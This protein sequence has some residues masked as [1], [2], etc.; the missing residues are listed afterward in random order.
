VLPERGFPGFDIPAMRSSRVTNRFR[1]FENAFQSEENHHRQE[2]SCLPELSPG[3]GVL[4]AYLK[5][6]SPQALALFNQTIQILIAQD[7]L[8]VVEFL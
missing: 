4:A 6:P 2:N 7:N 1:L 8:I 5:S 3:S